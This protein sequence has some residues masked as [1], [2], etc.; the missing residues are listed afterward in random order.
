MLLNELQGPIKG[1]TNVQDRY[2]CSSPSETYDVNLLFANW[3]DI[4]E[5]TWSDF[6]M[7]IASKINLFPPKI[8]TTILESYSVVK[9]SK[10]STPIPPEHY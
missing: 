7:I 4:L 1:V 8:N 9:D 10:K 6:Q 3:W 2:T 5:F